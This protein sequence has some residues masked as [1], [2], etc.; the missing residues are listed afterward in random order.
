MIEYKVNSDSSNENRDPSANNG[1]NHQSSR[2]G[3][4]KFVIPICISVFIVSVISGV[5][6]IAIGSCSSM[7][8]CTGIGCILL[9]IGLIITCIPLD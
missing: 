4:Y 2:L 6:L 1:I 8:I 5:L 3:R 9:A 7:G